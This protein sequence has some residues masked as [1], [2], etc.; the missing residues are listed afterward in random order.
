MTKNILAE[1]MASMQRPIDDNLYIA[2]T[3]LGTPDGKIRWSVQS[4]WFG[5]TNDKPGRE[6]REASIVDPEKML[7]I[8]SALK[9]SFLVVNSPDELLIFHMVGGNALVEQSVA[10]K[11]RPE[12]TEPKPV[13]QTGLVGFEHL[14]SLPHGTLNRAPTPKHRMRILKRD[15]YRCKICG[16]R[17]SDYVDL[18]LHLHH[19]R[20]WASGGITH[21]DNLITLCH[22][23]HN[24]LSPHEDW[25]LFEF[26]GG[27]RQQFQIEGAER[28]YWEGVRLYREKSKRVF[29]RLYQQRS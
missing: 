14:D 10:N 15:D 19:I 12:W 9:Q 24:G 7:M 23:C 26:I 1:K 21:D 17:P 8:W 2:V 28:E 5:F 13:A 11:Y 20:P 6:I 25:N 22:T 18:E 16:R 27:G 29:E 3:M 4:S